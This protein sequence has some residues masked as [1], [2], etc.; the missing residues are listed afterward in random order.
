MDDPGFSGQKF[1]FNT[2]DYIEFFNKLNFRDK[3]RICV[4]GGVDKNIVKILDVD[5][6]VSNSSILGSKDPINEIMKFQSNNS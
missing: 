2:F 6:I 4:D 3:F 1:N 5:D